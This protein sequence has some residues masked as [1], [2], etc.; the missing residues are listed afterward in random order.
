MSN[1]AHTAAQTDTHCSDN[2]DNS[3]ALLLLRLRSTLLSLPYCVFPLRLKAGALNVQHHSA[4]VRRFPFDGALGL[5][6]LAVSGSTTRKRP[7]DKASR[8]KLT[9]PQHPQAWCLDTSTQ[10]WSFQGRLSRS[11]TGRTT[12]LGR[13]PRTS[14]ALVSR[15]HLM[16]RAV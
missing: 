9:P 16:N 7:R 3:G 15:H 14:S 10:L 4:Q 5:Q 13:H 2:S 8:G 1:A 12:P 11:K 6:T